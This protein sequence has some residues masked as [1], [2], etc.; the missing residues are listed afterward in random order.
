MEQ[1]VLTHMR[2]HQ[3]PHSRGTR[4]NA[5]P[6]CAGAPAGVLVEWHRLPD[7]LGLLRASMP[8]HSA[9][10]RSQTTLPVAHSPATSPTG[11]TH[12]RLAAGQGTGRHSF[13]L[14]SRCV[15]ARWHAC[16][17]LGSSSG[18]CAGVGA[19]AC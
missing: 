3:H 12:P 2:K 14:P 7:H 16:A 6:A 1:T 17:V 13:T 19:R 9:T 11:H 5:P 10:P 8:P 4:A 15:R 18:G